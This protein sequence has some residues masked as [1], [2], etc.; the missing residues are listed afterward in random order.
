MFAAILYVVTQTLHECAETL[1]AVAESR[2]PGATTP[3]GL[4]E[5]QD[6]RPVMMRERVPAV[7]RAA[8]AGHEHAEVLSTVVQIA[9]ENGET[10]HSLAKTIGSVSEV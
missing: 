3:Y 7:R 1:H 5:A 9:S 2:D 6:L 10:R 4:A 8:D